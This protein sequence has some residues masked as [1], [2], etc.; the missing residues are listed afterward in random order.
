MKRAPIVIAAVV[1]AAGATTGFADDLLSAK[2]RLRFQ[3]RL[4]SE[5]LAPDGRVERESGVDTGQLRTWFHHSASNPP[6]SGYLAARFDRIH[7]IEQYEVSPMQVM[8]EH[9]ELGASLALFA[10][11]LGTTFGAWDEDTSWALVGAAAAAGA[12]WG[13]TRADEP[14][15]RIRYRWEP[16]E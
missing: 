6:E 1:L 8:F 11:A 9:A 15:I 14:G 16:R 4:L 5:S 3:N 12:L 10:S 13:G 7:G 2:L